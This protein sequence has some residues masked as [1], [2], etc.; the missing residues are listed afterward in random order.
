MAKW[1]FDRILALIGL[2]IVSPVLLLV[3]FVVLSNLGLPVLFR[4]KRVGQGGRLF[5]LY[6]F[7]TLLNGNNGNEENINTTRVG[8]FLRRWKLDELP[9]LWNVL[10]CDMSFVGPRPELPGYA[11]QLQGNDRKILTI[12]PGITGPATLKYL[13]EEVWLAEKKDPES[14]RKTILFPD[15]VKI[16]LK[17]LEKKSF[18]HDL[19]IIAY[20]LIRK[21][22]QEY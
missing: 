10:R 20:T 2:V 21:K 18:M 8:Y 16:N 11:D 15:K 12:K 5:I 6:K 17:Y 7:R 4:Q 1:W 3:S 9:E 19:K 14:Y 22:M 13:D